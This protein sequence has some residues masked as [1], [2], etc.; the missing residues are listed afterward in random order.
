M[1]AGLPR[2]GVWSQCHSLAFDFS[3]WEIW[4]ALLR[5]RPAGGGARV[6]GGL[7]GRPP[8]RAGGGTGQRVE[9][10]PVGVLALQRCRLQRFGVEWRWCWPVRP[11]PVEVVD[12]LGA[13]GGVMI[14]VYGLTETTMY[15][16]VSATANGG[17]GVWCRSGRR[18]R[19]RRFLCWMGGCGRCR[20]GWSG[21]CMWPG[22]GVAV[23]YVG[24][25]GLTGVAVCG[26]PVRRGSAGSA[27]VSHRGSG[28]LGRRWAA[29]V[30]GARR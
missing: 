13:P 12:R 20:R 27:D 19:G 29:A 2:A 17:V 16:A 15:A 26:V 28:V 23:G 4:G 14:N 7:A 24:R 3:V 5:W 22:A 30:C 6:G 11:D 21:S 10:D 25:A 9:P 1:D 18:W 8:R